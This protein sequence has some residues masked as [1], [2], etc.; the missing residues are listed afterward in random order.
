MHATDWLDCRLTVRGPAA[1]VAAFRAAAAGTGVVPWQVDHAAMEEDL[2]HRL[3]L[4]CAGTRRL[5][6]AGCHAFAAQFRERAEARHA[7]ALAL[8]APA[9]PLDLHALVPVP[10]AVLALGPDDARALAWLDAHWG[11]P[12]L[13]RIEAGP[14]APTNGDAPEGEATWEVAFFAAD[15]APEPAVAQLRLEW[16]ALAL[17]LSQ[18]PRSSQPGSPRPG[19]PERGLRQPDPAESGAVAPAMAGEAMCDNTAVHGSAPRR[20]RRTGPAP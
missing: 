11:T 16:P 13:R 20:P 5:S 1:A 7:R 14:P 19:S 9:C 3:V 6:V 2:F 15:R 17:S 18:R 10:A 4:A 8:D 12:T